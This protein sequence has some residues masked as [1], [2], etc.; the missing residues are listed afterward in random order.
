MLCINCAIC[1][2]CGF[3]AFHKS[4]KRYLGDWLFAWLL[5]PYRCEI[6]GHRELKLRHVADKATNCC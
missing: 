1:A 2:K 3:S 5:E 4:R 6:C